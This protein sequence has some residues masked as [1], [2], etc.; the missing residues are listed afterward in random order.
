[1]VH[2]QPRQVDARRVRKQNKNQSGFREQMDSAM[3]E[4]DFGDFVFSSSK[5]V[6]D[7]YDR[8][9]RLIESTGERWYIVVNYHH[10]RT[11][12][13]AWVAFAHR[14]KKVNLLIRGE[15]TELD[16]RMI[17][18]LGDPLL[19]GLHVAPRL[20]LD[21]GILQRGLRP[22]SILPDTRPLLGQLR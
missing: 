18:E 13:E 10:C 3:V 15:K 14:G 4:V 17:D 12:P 20:L 21:L 16:K 19:V 11:W 1:M 22:V 2:A 7:F 8:L 5:I 6:N 9:D